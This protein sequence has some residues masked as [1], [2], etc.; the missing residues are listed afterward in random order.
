METLSKAF[1]RVIQYVETDNEG[2]KSSEVLELLWVLRD[3]H[4]KARDEEL[5]REEA[6]ETHMA[7]TVINDIIKHDEARKG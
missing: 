3:L 4:E 6:E 5:D 2:D 7:N 1:Q